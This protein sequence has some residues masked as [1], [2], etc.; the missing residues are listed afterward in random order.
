M[1]KVS[2]SRKRMQRVESLEHRKPEE[3]TINW[4]KRIQNVA[5]AKINGKD[6]VINESLNKLM[7]A[8]LHNQFFL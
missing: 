1:K 8:T 4:S 3:N 2:L 6:I 5:T 7:I